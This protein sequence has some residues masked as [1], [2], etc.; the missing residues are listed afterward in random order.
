MYTHTDD[1]MCKTIPL[2][3]VLMDSKNAVVCSLLL[4][5]KLNEKNKEKADVEGE[6][7]R[8]SKTDARGDECSV[9]VQIKIFWKY[10]NPFDMRSFCHS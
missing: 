3:V 8:G 10:S 5:K 7:K 1:E 6:S 9:N 2:A 4:K